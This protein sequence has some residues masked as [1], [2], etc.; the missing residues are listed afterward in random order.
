MLGL[1]GLLGHR[2]SASAMS[3]LSL[4]RVINERER[5]DRLALNP[6]PFDEVDTLAEQQKTTDT[7][8]HCTPRSRS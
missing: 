5:L 4:L 7:E 2:E 3:A 1:F 8:H 6:A